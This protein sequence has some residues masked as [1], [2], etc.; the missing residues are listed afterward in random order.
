LIM[1]EDLLRIVSRPDY[2]RF[3]R[4][5]SR[6]RIRKGDSVMRNLHA[7][8]HR[9]GT[10]RV[11]TATSAGSRAIS[12]ALFVALWASLPRAADT[13]APGGPC[14]R[15]RVTVDGQ[16]VLTD[17]GTTL[18]GACWCQDCHGG[19]PAREEFTALK[20]AGLNSIHVYVEKNDDKPVGFEAEHIDSIV[21]WCRQESLYVVMTFGNSYLAGG[22][23]KVSEF[24]RF[25]APR[26]KDMTHVIYEEKNEGCYMTGACEEPAMQCYRD[27]YQIIRDVAPNTHIMLM[28]HSNLKG[29]INGLYRDVERLG[30][31]I[32]WTNASFAFHGYGTTGAFQE[33]AANQLG[34]DGYAMSCTEFP[35]NNAGDLARAYERAGISYFWFEACW[36][37]ARTPGNIKGYLSRVGISWQPDFG[38][39]PQAHVDH[40][41]IVRTINVSSAPAGDSRFLPGTRLSFPGYPWDGVSAAYDLRGRVVW[42]AAGD[43]PISPRAAGARL[44]ARRPGTGMLVVKY[45]H[46]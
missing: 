11:V 30:A 46:E 44:D 17:W 12:A 4:V 37:G 24:W 21:E 8:F 39:W 34:G 16:A 19:T 20:M 42:R 7:T 40:P 38:D 6:A 9:P 32:D 3:P 33:Q 10:S 14:T 23:A 41:D 36:G 25:Y 43:A 5:Q 35:F 13:F 26:Y 15:G 22:Y 31:E 28:S 18:R 45:L 27:C 29:G 2:T 1:D